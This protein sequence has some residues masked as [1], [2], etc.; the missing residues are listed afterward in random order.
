MND[1]EHLPNREPFLRNWPL[2]LGLTV[3]LW[4]G[5]IAL[6]TYLR[7]REVGKPLVILTCAVLFAAFWIIVPKLAK[8]K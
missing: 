2:I 6:G 4:A 7:Y 8:S 5:V 3:L 1:S